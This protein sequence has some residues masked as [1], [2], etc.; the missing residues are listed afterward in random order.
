MSHE[1][2]INKGFGNVRKKIG[3]NLVINWLIPIVLVFILRHFLISDSTAL[4]IAGIIPAVR[5]ITLLFWHRRIDWIGIISVFGFI[6]AFLISNFLGGSAL[7]LK[8]YH[9]V[10]TGIIGLVFLTS[11]IIR[12]PL[13][14]YLLRI[15]KHMDNVEINNA[16][17]LGKITLITGIIGF[18]FLF[19][20]AAHIIMALS[21]STETYLVMSKVVTIVII[22]ALLSVRLLASRSK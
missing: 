17:S 13:L 5:T 4:A 11:A 15:F 18:V 7:P 22:A 19:D 12:K 1:K 9:P 3:I 8:L 6:A 14:L 2:E 21:L 16:K 20:A 10:V